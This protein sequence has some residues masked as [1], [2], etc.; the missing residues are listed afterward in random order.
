MQTSIQS[1]AVVVEKLERHKIGY[2]LG[3]SGLL[4]SLGL[5]DKVGDWDVMTEAPKGDVLAA[6]Q[7]FEVHEITSGDYPF[8]SEY[9][10]I[11]RSTSPQVEIIGRFSIYCDAGLCHIPSIPLAR[12]NGIQVG[13]PEAWYVAYA[14]MSRKEKADMLLAHMKQT[15][16]RESIVRQ[17]MQE[18]LPDDI[19]RQLDSLLQGS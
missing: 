13:S 10:L 9:K 18:P 1:L 14:L 19:R 11:V 4:C 16:F 17:L 3:G 2:T 15:E 12:W 6:L 7:D 8:A 5:A